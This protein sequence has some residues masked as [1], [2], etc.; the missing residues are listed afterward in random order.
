MP[1]N[2]EQSA[3][4]T[5]AAFFSFRQDAWHQL[6]T[7]VQDATTAEEALKLAHLTGWNVRK[8]P[9]TTSVQVKKGRKFETVEQEVPNYF[10][11]VRDNP[12]QKGQ[13]D[14]FSVLG[15]QFQPIQNEDHAGLLNE[16]MHGAQIE[17]AGSLRG[18]REVFVTS[19]LPETMKIGGVDEVKTYISA[20]NTHDGSK[21]FRFIVTPVRIVCSN[22]QAAAIK[23]ASNTF[24]VRHTRNAT[25]GVVQQAREALDLTYRYQEE[26]QVEADKMIQET[27]TEAAFQDIVSRLYP[28]DTDASKV[29]QDRASSHQAS[30]MSLFADSPTAS[31]IRGTNWAGYN[32]VTEYVDHFMP[33]VGKSGDVAETRRAELAAS[34]ESDPLKKL[35]WSLLQVA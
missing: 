21:S 3:D 30:L 17:T 15:R 32:A 2:I 35:A 22:T 8:T 23:A 19:S 14:T 10:A 29:V 6:G 16:L 28:I 33:I 1:D 4:G 13:V 20:L 26:F 9:L 11:I 31:D 12:F 24:F 25:T 18:G 27:L 34:G 7:V 5:K